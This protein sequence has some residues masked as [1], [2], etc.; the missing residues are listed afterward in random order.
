MDGHPAPAAGTAAGPQA[1]SRTTWPLARKVAI[2]Y[3]VEDEAAHN[4]VRNYVKRIKEEL[5]ISNVMALGYS[6]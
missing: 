3:M 1:R 2:V 4:H 5:G 6:R